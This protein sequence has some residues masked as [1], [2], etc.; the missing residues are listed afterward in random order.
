MEK[1]GR[2]YQLLA[3]AANGQRVEVKLPFTVEFDV[4]RNV[5]SSANTSSIR[6]TNLSEQTR[7]LLYKDKFAYN[8]YRSVELKAGYGNTM[9]TIF[10]GNVQR[11]WSVRQ[12]VDFITELESSDGGFAMVNGQT[13]TSYPKG[14]S[15]N[16]IL[17]SIVN[18]LP[19]A[20]KGVLGSFPGK[21]VRG[22]TFSGNTVDLL[23]DLTNGNFFIDLERVYC[24][25]DT[26]CIQGSVQVI[27]S[28]SGLLGTP[29]REET[30]LTFDILFEPRLLIGQ[31]V[32]LRSQTA[33][34]F[35]GLYK[36]ISL[37]HKGT[38]SNSVAG[39]AVT[40][41]GLWFGPQQLKVVN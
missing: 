37:H 25:G 1:F 16:A 8:V 11:C 39:T 6:V 29:V 12:G 27:T 41:V 32:E 35:N 17:D 33:K 23:R 2:T 28:E 9:P 19:Q 24:L 10:K 36:V 21:T 5:L 30:V 18:T 22:N 38:I 3:D 40:T 15:N 26:E 31:L 34:N 20:K 7:K 4:I 13:A 14:T